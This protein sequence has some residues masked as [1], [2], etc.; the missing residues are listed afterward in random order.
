M[1]RS[2]RPVPDRD[3]PDLASRGDASGPD[4]G[5]GAA[6]PRRGRGAAVGA[7][8]G[9]RRVPGDRR[10]QRLDRRQRRRRRGPGRA[11]RARAASGASARPATPACSPPPRTS[12][13]L[14]RRR[15]PRS[16]RSC[17]R[18]LEPVRGGPTSCSA[19]VD[20]RR[21]PRG[22]CTLRFANRV[23][24]RRLARR[25]GRRAARPRADAG[26][27]S[28]G[29]ARPRPA[30]PALRLSARDGRP[31]RRARAGASRRSTSTTRRGTGA[32]R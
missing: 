29:A 10:R 27:A 16:R 6:V 25:T 23:L 18:V 13:L 19:G 17:D 14:R 1:E 11:R 3:R 30:G 12:W 9:A 31:R 26:G 7:P 28:D 32:R 20:R 22:R 4:G 24:A 2:S 8:A 21:A 15:Q 5:P